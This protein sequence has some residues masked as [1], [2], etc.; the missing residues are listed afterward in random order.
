MK[1][2]SSSPLD[3]RQLLSLLG[4]F[5]IGAEALAQDAAVSNPRSYKVLFENDRIRALGY[6]SRPGLGICGQGKHSHPAHLAVS[7][8]AAKAKVTGADGKV[9]IAESAPGDVFWE[10]PVTHTVENIGGANVRAYIVEM[11]GANW[12]ASTG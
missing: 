11:K 6:V 4:A 5:G 9:F 3:R 7:L 8:T 2:P 1:K 10:D 12:Q